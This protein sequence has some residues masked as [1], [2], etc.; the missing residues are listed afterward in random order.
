M[1]LF[2]NSS[3]FEQGFRKRKCYIIKQSFCLEKG[4]IFTKKEDI[5][6]AI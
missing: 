5:P 6:A 1:T 4:V 3:P 2:A